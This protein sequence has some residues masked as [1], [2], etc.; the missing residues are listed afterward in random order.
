MKTEHQV[1]APLVLL[2]SEDSPID[3]LSTGS[4]D[5]NGRELRSHTVFGPELLAFRLS[6][7]VVC[8]RLHLLRAAALLKHQWHLRSIASPRI[9]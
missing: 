6:S 9:E 5:K 1:A 8:G 7:Q 2:N 3:R 4:T